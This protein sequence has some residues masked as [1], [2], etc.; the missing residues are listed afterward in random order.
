MI[1]YRNA[2]LAAVLLAFTLLQ[3]AHTQCVVGGGPE[4]V[5]NGH[6]DAGAT[7]FSSDMVQ[8][9]VNS[10]ANRWEIGVNANALHASFTGVGCPTAPFFVANGATAATRAWFQTVNVVPG[11]DYV[12]SAKVCNVLNP[13]LNFADPRLQLSINGA[14]VGVPKTLTELPDTWDS[15]CFRWNSGVNTTALLAVQALAVASVGNDYA[16][17]S[18]TFREV[19]ILEAPEQAGA[20]PAAPETS[21]EGLWP[22]PV[23]AGASVNFPAHVAKVRTWNERGRLVRKGKDLQGL[24]PGIYFVRMVDAE[25]AATVEKLWIQ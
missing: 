19:A 13:S 21:P 4:L 11:T 2:H 7:G 5:V 8:G 20:A 24:P 22:N 9:P 10:G 16:I 15:L 17:D 12:F 3:H 1:S 6:F 23:T 14:L 18:I 25:G